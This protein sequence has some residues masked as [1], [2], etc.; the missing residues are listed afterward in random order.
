MT[1]IVTR[2]HY[3]VTFTR[4][5]LSILLETTITISN[6]EAR[7]FRVLILVTDET[8][9]NVTLFCPAKLAAQWVG[10]SST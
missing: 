9:A 1:T 6:S 2:K 4:T 3:S 10:I 7:G 8:F 5:P